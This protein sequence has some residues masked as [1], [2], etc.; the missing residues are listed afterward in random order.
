M[1]A[2]GFYF[3]ETGD[4]KVSITVDDAEVVLLAG[5]GTG[6]QAVKN[7]KAENAVIFNLAGQRVDANYKGVVIAN[8]Q[9]KIQK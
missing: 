8:G 9:K 3:D 6:I 7:V 1:T 5:N 2:S 4:A